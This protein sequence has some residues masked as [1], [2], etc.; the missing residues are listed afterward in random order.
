LVAYFTRCSRAAGVSY[1]NF[2][3]MGPTVPC[4]VPERFDNGPMGG[5]S[6]FAGRLA[7]GSGH[8]QRGS[9]IRHHRGESTLNVLDDLGEGGVCRD[10]VVNGGVLLDGCV[11]EVTQ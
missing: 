8:A 6:A 5:A 4:P 1:L 2:E 9:L 10:K 11:G 7:R 3:T